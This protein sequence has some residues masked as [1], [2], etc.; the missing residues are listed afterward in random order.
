MTKTDDTQQMLRII[1]NGQSTFRQEVLGKIDKLDKKLTDR[2]DGLENNL[3][4]RIDLVEKN[5]TNRIDKLGMKL[6]YLEDDTPNRE[7]FDKLE[8]RVTKIERKNTPTL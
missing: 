3:S 6:A 8:Q 2:I 4:Q 1:I 5:L 7:E